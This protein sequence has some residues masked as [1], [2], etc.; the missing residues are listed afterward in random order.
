MPKKRERGIG[1]LFKMHGCQ[2]WYAQFY[3]R[4]KR[5]RVSTKT[6]SKERAQGILRNLMTDR[7]RG[8][9]FVGDLKKVRYADLRR[10]LL[11][12]YRE[13][14]NKS[15][16]ITS[17]GRESIC[18]LPALDEFFE[19]GKDKPGLP[20]IRITT[21]AA[22]EFTKKRLAQGAANDTCNGSLALLRRML[23]LAN[24]DGKLHVVP[25]IPLLKAGAA[26]KG[27][28]D[29]SKFQELLGH[30]PNNL[31][32]LYVFLYY[33]GVRLGE[34]LQMEWPRV[35]LAGKMVRLEGNQTKN[36]E[37]REIP[38]PDSLI[39][40]LHALP[41]DGL[42]FDSTNY[43]KSWHKACV[44]VGLGTLEKVEGKAAEMY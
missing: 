39:T 18:G 8:V 5:R 19:Y 23:R 38:L 17:D 37:P 40:M 30:I 32:P 26:R 4:G 11:Q 1:G 34:A 41:K 10:G 31:K 7:D 6:A 13:R 33:C 28:L 2:Y 15:L 21:D 20:V 12:S 24:E 35:D 29:R 3:D 9:Q 25:K 16:I 22:R 42:V 43:R 36:S 44:A 14:G 27:F